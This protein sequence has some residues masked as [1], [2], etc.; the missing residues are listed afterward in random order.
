MARLFDAESSTGLDRY[1]TK[2]EAEEFF[3]YLQGHEKTISADEALGAA[4]QIIGFY[5]AREVFNRD[6]F[7]RGATAIFA[8]YPLYAVKRVLDPLEGIPG[9]L[10]FLPTLAEIKAAL[11]EEKVRRGRMG[12]NCLAV[13]RA[14][15]HREEEEEYERNKGTY[16]ERARKVQELLSTLGTSSSSN[17]SDH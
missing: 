4:E 3:N 11:D 5:P 8:A 17:Q 1:A 13:L 14:H 9:K 16:E 2:A 10:K 15:K 6:I 7:I 12:K